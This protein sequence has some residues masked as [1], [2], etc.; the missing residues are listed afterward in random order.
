MNKAPIGIIDMAIDN[1]SFLNTV[2]DAF[3]AEHFI[4]VN[5]LEVKDY[6][7]MPIEEIEKRVQSIVD[8]LMAR[9]VKLIVVVSN[10]IME[11]CKEIFNQIAVPVVNIVD[12]IIQEINDQYEHKN[13]VFLA[14]Q[15]IMQANMFQK[16]FRYNHLYNIVSDRLNEIVVDKLTK[17]NESFSTT[18][19]LFKGVIKKDVDIIILSDINLECLKTEIK[20]FMREAD[21]LPISEILCDKIKAALLAIENINHK[22]KTKIEICLDKTFSKLKLSHLVQVKYKLSKRE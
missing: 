3:K 11:Y 16:H 7:G 20:E 12:T 2:K 17:T 15:N 10:T 21:I 14:T 13:M 19:E 5:D 6:E 1:I 22:G 18:K 9:G 4:Y 8:Y